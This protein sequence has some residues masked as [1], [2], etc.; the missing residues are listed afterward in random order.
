[1]TQHTLVWELERRTLHRTS[2]H[3]RSSAACGSIFLPSAEVCCRKAGID[4]SRAA[5]SVRAG[6]ALPCQ[7]WQRHRTRCSLPQPGSAPGWA[8]P[9]EPPPGLPLGPPSPLSASLEAMAFS[10]LRNY[11]CLRRLSKPPSQLCTISSAASAA[12]RSLEAFPENECTRNA[13]SLAS[14]SWSCLSVSA[15][16]ASA[17]ANRSSKRST[18]LPYSTERARMR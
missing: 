11:A 5:W 18:A 6:S 9:T 4:A 12:S 14:C 7:A 10:C 8:D 2:V 13:S 16:S 3:P 15:L 1:M 17:L